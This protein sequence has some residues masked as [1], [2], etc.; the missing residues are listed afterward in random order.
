MP[1][2]R[3]RDESEELPFQS[4]ALEQQHWLEM[5]DGKVSRHHSLS[6]SHGVGLTGVEQRG[7]VAGGER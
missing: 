7:F 1:A 4:K 3:E 6:A 5:I 2:G